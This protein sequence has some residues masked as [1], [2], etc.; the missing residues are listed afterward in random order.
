[1]TLI[2]GSLAIAKDLVNLDKQE[3]KSSNNGD[4]DS[5]DKE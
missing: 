1:M 5:T 3:D 2:G 4:D